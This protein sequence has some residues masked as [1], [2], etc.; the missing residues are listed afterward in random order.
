MTGRKQEELWV[1]VSRY[2]NGHV[3]VTC[4]HNEGAGAEYFRRGWFFEGHGAHQDASDTAQLIVDR[5][6][7]TGVLGIAS[8]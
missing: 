6:T 5:W 4:R 3:I 8:I 1:T 7:Q 2:D